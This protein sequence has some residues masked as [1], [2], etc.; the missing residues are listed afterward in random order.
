MHL[1]KCEIVSQLTPHGTPRRN[2]VSEYRNRTLLDMVQCEA[3]VDG[4]LCVCGRHW[5]M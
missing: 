1:K 5:T 4:L 3:C 2:G